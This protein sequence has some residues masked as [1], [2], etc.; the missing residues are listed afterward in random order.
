MRDPMCIPCYSVLAPVLLRAGRYDEAEAVLRRRI[1]LVDD[2]GGHHNLAF[3]LLLQGQPEAAF[4]IFD[5]IRGIEEHWLFSGALALHD[6]GRHAEVTEMLRRLVE[7][8]GDT[9]AYNIAGIYAY[10]GDSPSALSWLEKAIEEDQGS[11]DHWVVW[12]RIFSS[13]Y[14]TP[15]WMQWRKDA[16]LDAETLAAIEFH[17]PDLGR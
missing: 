7:D 1:D 10:I 8:Y 4:E 3:V 5:R 2:A 14:D 17:I 12:D 11:F 9:E 16:G 6:L 15:Q 13:L